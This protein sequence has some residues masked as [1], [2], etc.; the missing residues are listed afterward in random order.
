[1]DF[2]LLMTIICAQFGVT[3]SVFLTGIRTFEKL[4]LNLMFSVV[5]WNETQVVGR[6]FLS[7]GQRNIVAGMNGYR[8][9]MILSMKF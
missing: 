5:V 7:W 4:K 3:A 6:V 8:V 9:T 1:M 2:P